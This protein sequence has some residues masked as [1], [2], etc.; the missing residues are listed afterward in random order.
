MSAISRRTALGIAAA[1]VAA[2]AAGA[3]AV[4]SRACAGRPATRRVSP[5]DAA[6][7]YVDRDGWM[8]TPEEGEKL[9]PAGPTGS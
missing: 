9:S 8:L 2:V 1:G 7:D 5:K 3:T 4:G 6:V